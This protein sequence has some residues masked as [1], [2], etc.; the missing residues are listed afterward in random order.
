MQTFKSTLSEQKNTH[1]THIEDKVLYGGV[2][3]TRQAIM[4]LRSLRDMLKGTHEGNVSVKWDGAPAVFCGTDPRDGKFFVAKKGIF[5]KNPKVYKTDADIDA[6]TSGDLNTKLKLCLKYLPE[7]GIKGVVQ[8]DL[9]FTS[10]DVK[11]SKIK[12]DRFVTFHPNTIMYAVPAGTPAATTIKK[13]KIG[14]VWHTTYTG[15]TFETMKASYGVDVTKFRN[16]TNVWSQDAMLRDLTRYTMTKKDTDEVNSLLSDCGRIF[17]K[18]AGSTLRTLQANQELAGLIE[19]HANS[20]VRL[21]Q[22]PPDPTK[23][24]NALIQWIRQRYKKEIDKL[25]TE[26]GK[27]SKQ[28]KLDEILTFFSNENKINLKMMFELQQKIVLAKLKLI[29]ILNKLSNVDT[30]VKTKTGY[31]TTGPEGYVAIDKLGGDAVKIVDRME[32]SYNNFSPDILKGWDKP[33]R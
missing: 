8:G 16:S 13:S 24:V 9:L 1:M 20:Y 6:D 15:S 33:G 2:N 3:G 22:I 10:G 32:F 21:G 7:L 5:N 14:I 18:I 31:K 28:K 30:F 4:A 26:K 23:R 25:K 17:N 19:T 12:G 27:A 29:N 11:T